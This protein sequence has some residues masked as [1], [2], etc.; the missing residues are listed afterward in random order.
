MYKEEL[1]AL[2]I[3]TAE[4]FLTLANSD[5]T[6]VERVEDLAETAQEIELMAN[7]LSSEFMGLAHFLE[8]VKEAS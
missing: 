7:E 8:E 4:L 5:L 3:K 1:F 2:T 6:N